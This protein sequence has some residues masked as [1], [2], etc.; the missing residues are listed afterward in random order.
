MSST[1]YPDGC[2]QRCGGK[3]WQLI[4]NSKVFDG[5]RLC[6]SCHEALEIAEREA[7]AAARRPD[8]EA[9]MAARHAEREQEAAQEARR[10]LHF[11]ETLGHKERAAVCLIGGRFV[12]STCA[13]ESAPE[14]VIARLASLETALAQPAT[15]AARKAVG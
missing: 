2:C 15:K 13:G 10:V 3:S 1:K 12:C 14:R 9:A 8:L 6:L 7:K 4:S 11:C 5:K